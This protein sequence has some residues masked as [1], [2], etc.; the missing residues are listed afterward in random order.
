MHE[1]RKAPEPSQVTPGTAPSQGRQNSSASMKR[2]FRGLDY[3]AQVPALTPV[4]ASKT[5]GGPV[6]MQGGDD[7]ITWVPGTEIGKASNYDAGGGHSYKDHGA[8]TTKNN[9]RPA[10]RPASHRQVELAPS[11]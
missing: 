11:P 9:T 2:A 7:Q 8:H 10:S 4:Q 5:S 6:Q 1:S 3:D